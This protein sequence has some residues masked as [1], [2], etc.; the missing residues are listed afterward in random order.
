MS[1]QNVEVVRRVSEA[2]ARGDLDTVFA[3]V[4]PEIEWDFSHADTWLEEQSYQGYAAIM[5]FFSV[6][7]GEWDD[8]HF[9]LEEVIDAGDRVVAI[10]R[11]EGRAK[12]SGVKLERRHAEIWTLRG[13]RVVKIEPFDHKNE[14]L[15]AVGLE[16]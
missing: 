10:V 5:E 12:S 11:D 1:E 2:F 6:W 9:E 16:G 4:S 15:E 3:L 8:Y 13:G 14:A 7:V